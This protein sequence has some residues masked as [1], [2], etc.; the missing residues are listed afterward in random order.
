MSLS[1]MER[2]ELD[3]MIL[4]PEDRR[5]LHRVIRDAQ[6]MLAADAKARRAK[7]KAESSRQRENRPPSAPTRPVGET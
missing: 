2:M 3:R 1:A 7:A 4:D 6:G 5:T